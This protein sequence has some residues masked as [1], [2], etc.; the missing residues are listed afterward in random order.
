VLT[1]PFLQARWDGVFGRGVVAKVDCARGK[2]GALDDIVANNRDVAF[3]RRF[4]RLVGWLGNPGQ[5]PF[6]VVATGFFELADK[7]WRRKIVES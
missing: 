5:R 2:S 6:F 1:R 3:A 4:G 7:A